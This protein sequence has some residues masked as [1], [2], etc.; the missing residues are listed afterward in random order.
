MRTE[1]IPLHQR[2]RPTMIYLT[3]DLVEAMPMTAVPRAGL[4]ECLAPPP[5]HLAA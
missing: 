1:I 3:H 4:D 2:L 5:A